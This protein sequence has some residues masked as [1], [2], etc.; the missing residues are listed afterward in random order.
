MNNES[1]R[2]GVL[3]DIGVGKSELVHQICH[4]NAR[5]PSTISSL[6]GP[7]VDVLDFVRSDGKENIWVEFTII[8]SETRHQ[9]SRQML[10]DFNLDA[11][12]L[13]CNCSVPKTLLRA[14]EWIEEAA[15]T[16]NLLDVPVALILGGPRNID[17]KSSA[18]LTKLVEPLARRCNAKILD[19]SGYIASFALEPRQRL[20]LGDFYEQVYSHKKSKAGT[21]RMSSLLA[22]SSR[23]RK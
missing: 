8:P 10:Y 5:A 17:W 20:V 18:T 11:L 21:K 7:A 14:T 9:K 23:H 13:V 16:E 22:S 6:V 4:Q 3:G 15:A 12:F 19:M 1:I 2:I